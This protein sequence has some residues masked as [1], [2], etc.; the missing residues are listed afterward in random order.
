MTLDDFWKWSTDEYKFA[1]PL[2]QVF[3][4][5]SHGG[6]FL[7]K[8]GNW[9]D[10]TTRLWENKSHGHHIISVDSLGTEKQFRVVFEDAARLEQYFVVRFG[11]ALEWLPDA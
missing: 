9:K 4:N 6:E 3:P 11:G 10:R 8:K 7:R 2:P 5:D 1:H